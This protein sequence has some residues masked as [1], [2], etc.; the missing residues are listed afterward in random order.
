MSLARRVAF[1]LQHDLDAQA[2]IRA[3]RAASRA[4]SS[5]GAGL[6]GDD[7]DDFSVDYQ[8]RFDSTRSRRTAVLFMTEGILQKMLQGGDPLLVE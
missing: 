4:S 2:R 1:E 8:I 7:D 6:G 3:A 5:V